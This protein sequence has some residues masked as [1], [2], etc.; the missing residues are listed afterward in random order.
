[1]RQDL[2]GH[3]LTT[4]TVR[5]AARVASAKDAT[6]KDS[7]PIIPTVIASL[8]R[9]AMCVTSCKYLLQQLCQKATANFIR[10]F[11]VGLFSGWTLHL[12]MLNG[13]DLD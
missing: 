10:F 1:L 2:I 13:K 3:L 8:I 9:F 6:G 7:A 12:A 11:V 5:L 4:S